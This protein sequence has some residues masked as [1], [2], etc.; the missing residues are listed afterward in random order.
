MPCTRKYS[1]PHTQGIKCSARHR[2]EQGTQETNAY[3]SEKKQ[4]LNKIII[5]SDKCN[6]VNRQYTETRIKLYGNQRLL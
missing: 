3:S 5:N 1:L 4:T 6:E 2:A